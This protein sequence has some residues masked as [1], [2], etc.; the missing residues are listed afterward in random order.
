MTKGILLALAGLAVLSTGARAADPAEAD[1]PR[2]AP[3]ALW[4]GFYA[5]ANAGAAIDAASH[6][7]APVG[8]RFG[9]TLSAADVESL[10]RSGRGDGLGFAGGL[11]GGYNFQVSRF[12]V[13]FETDIARAGLSGR[14]SSLADLGSGIGYATSVRHAVD[15]FGTVRG[16]IAYATGPFLLY[17]TGGFAYGD[18]RVSAS[19]EAGPAGGPPVL[20]YAGK[21]SE[22]LAG[23]SAGGGVEYA[24]DRNLSLRAEYLHV[25]LGAKSVDAHARAGV[26]G[27]PVGSAYLLSTQARFDVVRAG[28]N[29]RW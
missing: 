9:G 3:P 15:W 27:L 26:A 7:L 1:A 13:G 6:R 10:S 14:S 17:G 20:A 8:S 24:I 19:A 16:R 22:L 29:Y 25:D 18:V 11:Q 2:P 4:S 23:W 21:G 28:V 5:G 12:L